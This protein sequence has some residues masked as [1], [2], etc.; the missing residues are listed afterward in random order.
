MPQPPIRHL[1]DS[2]AC[3]L[4]SM[5]LSNHT[6]IIFFLTPCTKLDVKCSGP[7]TMSG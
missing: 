3:W 5:V 6:A 1:W 7:V 4:G 2:G